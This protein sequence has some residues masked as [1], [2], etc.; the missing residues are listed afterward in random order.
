MSI[1]GKIFNPLNAGAI[2]PD[3]DVNAVLAEVAAI[4]AIPV[5]EV[6]SHPRA[7]AV[8]RVVHEMHADGGDRSDPVRTILARVGDRW[9][10]LLVQLLEPAPMRFSQLRRIVATILNEEIS[11]QILSEKLHGLERDGFVRRTDLGGARPAVEYSL[12]ATGMQFAA[13][14]KQLIAWARV[15]IPQVRAARASYHTDPTS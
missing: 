4:L 8:F 13:Q 9:T 14:I 6:G 1:R 15:V 2:V 11:K 5:S 12:T 7:G 10:P 3:R